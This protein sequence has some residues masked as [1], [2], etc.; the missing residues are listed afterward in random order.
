MLAVKALHD[1]E[2]RHLDLKAEN[3]VI[4]DDNIEGALLGLIDFG[5]C[6]DASPQADRRGTI[7]YAP[8]ERFTSEG[9][10]DP[11]KIDIFMLGALLIT[12][13]FRDT[14]FTNSDGERCECINDPWYNYY[15]RL[16]LANKLEFFLKWSSAVTEDLEALNLIVRMID[17][18]PANRPSLEEV[19]ANPF[20]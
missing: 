3:L 12:I 11:T 20:I 13:I 5:Y 9:D 16:G 15:I 8:P 2:L 18:N 19:L 4:L 14:P 7:F 1:A 17:Y 10:V 6:S